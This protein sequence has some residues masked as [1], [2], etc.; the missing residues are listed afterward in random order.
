M[1]ELSCLT[2]DYCSV[3]DPTTCGAELRK[4]KFQF[5][6]VNARRHS[7]DPPP[8]RH[9]TG[10]ISQRFAPKMLVKETGLRVWRHCTHFPFRWC[11]IVVLHDWLVFHW[12]VTPVCCIHILL[13][14]WVWSRD[15]L[16]WYTA[17]RED[18]GKVDHVA[19]TLQ[20]GGR[21]GDVVT[22]SARSGSRN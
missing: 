6:A 5:R 13:V 16:F 8:P 17:Y 19:I 12:D 2:T 9:A 15:E 7:A 18:K 11:H 3:F 22:K 14:S 21:A 10:A 20:P 1:H 4:S